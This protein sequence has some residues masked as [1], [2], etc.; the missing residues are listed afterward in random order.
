MAASVA[1]TTRDENAM[2]GNVPP[3]LG[4]R[5]FR[6]IPYCVYADY[7][8]S[9]NVG[10]NRTIYVR[11]EDVPVWERAREL[12]G[13]K[14]APVIVDGLKRFIVEKE[15]EVSEAKGFERIEVS[16]HDSDFNGLMKKRAFNG[17]WVFPLKS[18]LKSDEVDFTQ[19]YA[20]AITAKGAV[21]IISWTADHDGESFKRFRV[22]DSFDAAAAERSVAWAAIMAT[23]HLG[24]PVEEL[25]I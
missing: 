21:V 8:V 17:K 13:D 6:L 16:F 2:A 7:V 4:R 19:Y 12:A 14:L 22:Y 9:S 20:L 11:D 10:M 23:E 24:V 1:D 25:D 5:A 15:R 3:A 18:P